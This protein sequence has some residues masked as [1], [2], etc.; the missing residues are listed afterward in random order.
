[1]EKLNISLEFEKL[2]PSV[3]AGCEKFQCVN[4]ATYAVIWNKGLGRIQVCT[5]H[6]KEL[7]KQPELLGTWFQLGANRTTQN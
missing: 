4:D 3:T 5:T 6:K 2:M 7:E 1:M